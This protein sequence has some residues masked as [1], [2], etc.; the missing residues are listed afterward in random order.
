[1]VRCGNHVQSLLTDEQ[2][3]TLVELSQSSDKLLSVLIREALEQVYFERRA[4]D[5]R[6]A[7]LPR[8]LSL[9]APV[10]DWPETEKE[11]TERKSYL[12]FLSKGNHHGA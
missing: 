3:E 4:R 12:L 6:R 11:I 1:M 10:D 8:L 5:R 2:Y 7:N 9:Q